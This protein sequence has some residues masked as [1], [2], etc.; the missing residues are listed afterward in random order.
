MD[1]EKYEDSRWSRV[2]RGSAMTAD[3]ALWDKIN[4]LPFDIINVQLLPAIEAAATR[5]RQ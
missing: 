1:Y 2:T 5:A 3:N 4:G